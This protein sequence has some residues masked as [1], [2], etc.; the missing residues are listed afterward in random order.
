M[1]WLAALLTAALLAT[2]PAWADDKGKQGKTEIEGVITAVD[3]QGEFVILRGEKG[4][5]WV[6]AVRG[7]T[8]IK[9]EGDDDDEHLLS[10]A[11]LQD[12]QVGDKVER[13]GLVE[14]GW[15]WGR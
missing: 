7:A 13:L 8:E 15:G 11:G 4:R 9:F 6:V 10:P 12:L 3:P 5:T 1:R 2:T 14:A